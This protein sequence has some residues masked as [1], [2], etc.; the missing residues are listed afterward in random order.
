MAV[1]LCFGFWVGEPPVEQHPVKGRV[2]VFHICATETGTNCSSMGPLSGKVT[3]LLPIDP[4][5]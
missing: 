4:A 2:A 5:R 3:L 1:S